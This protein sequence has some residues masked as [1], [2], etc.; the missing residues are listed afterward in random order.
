MQAL[1]GT[2]RLSVMT[3]GNGKLG[4]QRN[5]SLTGPHPGEIWSGERV[6]RSATRWR[7]SFVSISKFH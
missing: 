1:T 4:Q 7:N 6:D 3:G 2:P 5:I